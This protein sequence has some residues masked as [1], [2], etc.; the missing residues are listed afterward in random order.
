[1]QGKFIIIS[2]T[3]WKMKTEYKGFTV[4]KHIQEA[5]Q[6]YLAQEKSS[7]KNKDNASKSFSVSEENE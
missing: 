1:M 4:V 5:E 3:W 7:S 2:K 6:K